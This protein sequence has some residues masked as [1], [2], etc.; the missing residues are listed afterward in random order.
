MEQVENFEE[1]SDYTYSFSDSIAGNALME[2]SAIV[3]D[4]S[5]SQ[6]DLAA[7]PIRQYEEKNKP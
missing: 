2:K 4:I 5:T 1:N 3:Y 7:E 6:M